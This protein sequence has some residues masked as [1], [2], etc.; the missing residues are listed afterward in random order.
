MLILKPRYTPK[1][2]VRKFAETLERLGACSQ[3][4]RKVKDYPS[5]EKLYEEWTDIGQAAWL[6]ARLLGNE[7][8]AKIAEKALNFYLGG[9]R[10]ENRLSSTGLP[11]A[12]II[13]NARNWGELTITEVE[14]VTLAETIYRNQDQPLWD[15]HCV[16]ALVHK[17]DSYLDLGAHAVLFRRIREILPQTTFLSMVRLSLLRKKPAN[18]RSKKPAKK[19][20]K[21]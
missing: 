16:Q 15:A 12:G 14:L 6:V 18:K 11:L 9:T 21:R 1:T 2:E 13:A 19:K 8:A 4:V 3:S 20:S 5:L 17:I 7:A 10:Q